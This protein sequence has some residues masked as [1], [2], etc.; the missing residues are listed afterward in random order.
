MSTATGE[1]RAGR[2]VLGAGAVLDVTHPRFGAP[3][4]GTGDASGPMLAAIAALPAGGGTIYLPA[5]SYR[6]DSR[7]EI[8][9]SD[10]TI[11]GDG[12][13]TVLVYNQP[14]PTTSQVAMILVRNTD[15]GCTRFAI[16]DLRVDGQGMGMLDSGMI[17][18]NNCTDWVFER[19]LMEDGGDPDDEEVRPSGVNAIGCGDG[20]TTAYPSTGIIRDS[21]FRRFT[22]APIAP[23]RGALDV[24]VIGNVVED[25][26][27]NGNCPGIQYNGAVGTIIIGNVVRRVEGSGIRGGANGA[28]PRQTI[29]ANN[30]IERSGEGCASGT[31]GGISV[32]FTTGEE[33]NTNTLITGNQ[34]YDSAI[35][36]TANIGSGIEITE[37]GG[38][39]VDGNLVVGSKMHGIRV[40]RS[41]DVT[42]LNNVVRNNNQVGIGTVAGI[43]ITEC[44]RIHVQGNRIHDNQ[45][46]DE[47]P[48][49]PDPTQDY[50]I[51]WSG[52]PGADAV[53]RDN[54]ILGN[55]TAPFGGTSPSGSSR[56]VNNLTDSTRAGL[57]SGASYSAV[58]EHLEGSGTPE[59]AITARVG[60][61]YHRTDGSTGTSFYV[62]E[63]GTGNTGWVAK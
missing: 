42:L 44:E 47:D 50:G 38:C 52:T 56:F 12:W 40:I 36:S 54:T 48:P 16:R 55:A 45:F 43:T 11:Q 49:P 1:I 9:R 20:G 13:R 17:Q 39:V 5:G 22:K 28:D 26:V 8:N 29:I 61:T 62:K 46:D 58:V 27:G 18:I 32:V 21:V 10:V 2:V 31:C 57:N 37:A 14:M 19:I 25:C 15:A 33:F 59:G 23:S 41:D 60:S 34:I 4:D 63:S 51:Y 3:N 53:V 24:R 6:M 30:I 35:N 7:V